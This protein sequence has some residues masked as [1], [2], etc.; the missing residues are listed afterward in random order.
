L[1]QSVDWLFR[2]R[3]VASGNVCGGI[4]WSFGGIKIKVGGIMSEFG[5]INQGFG[6]NPTQLGGIPIIQS[7]KSNPNPSPN[8]TK[9]TSI[10]SPFPKT[11]DS[12]PYKPF[13]FIIK[14]PLGSYSVS[15]IVILRKGNERRSRFVPGE[16]IV[17][18]LF[19]RGVFVV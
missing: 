3:G 16:P 13:F 5:G 9:L 12:F 8:Q 18:T 17:P 6:G 1:S 11:Y 7:T 19:L 14:K 4:N 15:D 10:Q 2:L